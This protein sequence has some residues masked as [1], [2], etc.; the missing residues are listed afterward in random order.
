MLLLLFIVA[1]WS[2]FCRV[3][4]SS[5]RHACACAR[6]QYR[7]QP[8]ESDFQLKSDAASWQHTHNCHTDTP[9]RTTCHLPH[10]TCCLLPA[11]HSLPHWRALPLRVIRFNGDAYLQSVAHFAALECILLATKCCTSTHSLCG[12]C[13]CQLAAEGC[14]TATATAQLQLATCSAAAAVAE[15]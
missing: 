13:S 9:T 2:P 5:S 12:C 8:S 10:A 1:T 15:P 4:C 7:T 14:P 3:C 6:G 11:C